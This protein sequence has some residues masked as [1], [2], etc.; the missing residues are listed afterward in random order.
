MP[1]P[2]LF[3]KSQGIA[4]ITFN[5]PEVRNAITLDMCATLTDFAA[6][7]NEDG[8]TRVL[9]L[10]GNG[11]DFCSGAD[12]RGMTD[13]TNFPPDERR[14][15]MQRDVIEISQTLFTAFHNIRAPTVSSVRGYAIGAGM[16][17]TLISDLVVASET[18]KLS[19]P[20]VRLGHTAD[21]GESYF[22]P[23]K[24]G[25]ARAMQIK[26]LGEFIAAD[27]AE[28]YGL[29]NWVTPDDA[30]EARTAEIV[31]TLAQSPPAASFGMKALLRTAGTLEQ[32]FALE[33]ETIG[34]CAA[35]QDF[36]EAMAAVRE[37]RKP[38][39]TGR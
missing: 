15:N 23:R 36:V 28:R 32:Q 14:A 3:E 7:L 20:Q 38:V 6:T 2:I 11:R 18:A 21:H 26:M 35:T 34:N 22:L 9:L 12:L 1:D 39:F 8:Q 31:N 13:I 33:V 27:Q 25:V 29:V 5:R 17:F 24:I 16:Q 19:I 4:S 10:R 37:K 30:L